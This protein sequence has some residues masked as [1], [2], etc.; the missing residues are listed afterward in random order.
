MVQEIPEFTEHLKKDIKIKSQKT[1]EKMVLD[2]VQKY[3]FN[4]TQVN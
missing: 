1:L 3:L 2:F 4:I